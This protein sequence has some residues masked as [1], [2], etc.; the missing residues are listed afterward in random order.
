M[1]KVRYALLIMAVMWLTSG[2]SAFAGRVLTV[3]GDPW[4]PYLDP[5]HHRLGLSAE[6]VREAF[7]TQGYRVEF[8]IIDWLKAQEMASR[9]EVILMN[10]WYTPDRASAFFVSDP[11]LRS[12]G[13]FLARRG[14]GFKYRGIESLKGLRVGRMRGY[15]YDPEFIKVYIPYDGVSFI[16]LARKV[17]SRRIDLVPEDQ[18]VALWELKKKE[19]LLLDKLQVVEGPLKETTVHLMASRVMPDGE[20]TIRAFNRG[21]KELKRSGQY[22]AILAAY[23]ASSVEVR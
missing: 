18:L 10:A 20:E 17:A 7:R 12:R 14:S 8:K 22:R 21:L 9:G 2:G 3:A 19:P 15:A 16:D 13:V 1:V 5:G 11:Y 4:G 6:L 23:G